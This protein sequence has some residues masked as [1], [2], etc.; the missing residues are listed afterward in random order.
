MCQPDLT[1]LTFDWKEGSTRPVPNY[2]VD[3]ECVNW[4]QLQGWVDQHSFSLDDGAIRDPNG[5]WRER[6]PRLEWI[7]VSKF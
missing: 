2:H 3:H 1:V 4:E 7:L 5:E 6:L